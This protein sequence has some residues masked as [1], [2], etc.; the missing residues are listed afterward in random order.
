[1]AYLAVPPKYKA[2]T[3]KTDDE[4]NTLMVPLAGGKLYTYYNGTT[5]NAPAYQD[6]AGDAQHTNPI[7][8]DENGEAP[9]FLDTS[10]TYTFD[11][12]DKDDNDVVTINDVRVNS[13]I[14][15]S[16]SNLEADLELSDRFIVTSGNT[17][18]LFIPNGTGVLSVFTSDGL[19]EQR[20]TSDDIIPNKKYVDD[21]S[22]GASQTQME[23][24]DLD[25][26]YASSNNIQYSPF[27]GNT[28]VTFT[29]DGSGNPTITD[30]YNV[31]SV[32]KYST[33][34]F[35]IT[36]TNDY[37]ADDMIILASTSDSG[38]Q[39]CVA[40]SATGAGTVRIYTYDS[41]ASSSQASLTVSVIIFG[42]LA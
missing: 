13:S 3:T 21:L 6:S 39:V 7:I 27:I 14:I 36:I 4:G 38:G 35:N 23:N 24:A 5:Q 41:S 17:D 1:M 31:D 10:I 40:N 25:Y 19:Y 33:L 8:L 32:S 20:V 37:A 26:V 11:I 16:T 22:T 9:I 2:F 42:K 15:T 28:W 34:G 18:I 29:T 12:D 30:S